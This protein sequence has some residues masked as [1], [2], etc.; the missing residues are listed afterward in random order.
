MQAT[1]ETISRLSNASFFYA[2]YDASHSWYA[3]H[4]RGTSRACLQVLTT[5]HVSPQV[6]SRFHVSYPEKVRRVR[7]C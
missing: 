4:S 1:S 2:H 6:C 7:S 3:S 5:V